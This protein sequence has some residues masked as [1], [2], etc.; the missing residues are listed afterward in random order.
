MRP[1]WRHPARV[2]HPA[3]LPELRAEPCC[4][5]VDNGGDRRP[6]DEDVAREKIA[7]REVDGNIGSVREVAEQLAD[8]LG[9]TELAEDAVV[10]LEDFGDARERTG[11]RS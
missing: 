10:V 7:V 4:L 8:E 2:V 11:W 9:L 5:P 3:V 6:I 1:L